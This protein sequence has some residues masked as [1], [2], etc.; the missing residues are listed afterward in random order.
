MKDLIAEATELLDPIRVSPEEFEVHASGIIASLLKV[1]CTEEGNAILKLN[2]LVG[3]VLRCLGARAPFVAEVDDRKYILVPYEETMQLLKCLRNDLDIPVETIP[4][5]E[6]DHLEITMID[7]VA[8]VIHTA[9]HDMI[10]QNRSWEDA[11]EDEKRL[12]HTLAEGVVSALR[13]E[14]IHRRK[15]G[16]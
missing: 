11:K 3:S 6:I 9:I 10:G 15:Q 4:G 1:I 12:F 14:F 16:G 7:S 8:Q 2:K 5:V 13:R